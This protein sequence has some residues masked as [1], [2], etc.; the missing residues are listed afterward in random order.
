MSAAELGGK[1]LHEFMNSKVCCS[2]FL[3]SFK[4]VYISLSGGFQCCASWVDRFR[5]ASI[6]SSRPSTATRAVFRSG[7]STMSR[8]M[9]CSTLWNFPRREARH[10]VAPSCDEVDFASFQLQSAEVHLL[11]VEKQPG[12]DDEDVGDEHD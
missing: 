10:A 7:T 5:D 2:G 8:K 6:M 1:S 11:A 12:D 9:Q 3:W 4:Q